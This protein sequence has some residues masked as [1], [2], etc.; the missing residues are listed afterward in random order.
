MKHKRGT[1]T[2]LLIVVLLLAGAS[3][4]YQQA[5]PKHPDAL[6]NIVSRQCVPHQQQGNP[7][8]CSEV[9]LRDGYVVLKDLVGPLQYLLMPVAKISGMESPQLLSDTTPNFFYQAWQAR[10]Y[11][12]DKRGTPIDDRA[13]SLAINSASGRTQNQLHIH[14][15]CLRP[16]I[17]QLLDRSAA[18]IDTRWQ[19][20]P[21]KI[22]GHSYLAKRL[23]AANLAAES[24]FLQLARE[25]PAATKAM[26]QFGMALAQL[27]DGSY[28]LL[29]N[30]RN[31]LLFNRA[32]SEEIQDHSCAILNAH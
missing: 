1:L 21:E 11:L 31:L 26:G 2:G 7:S 17:R 22:M 4:F 8:P 16:D 24:P 20:L 13:L 10:H 14:I 25:V 3:L 27:P 6:W 18:A 30:Q 28:V 12:S 15:S 19:P 5:R 29:A 9:N 23:S 32:S